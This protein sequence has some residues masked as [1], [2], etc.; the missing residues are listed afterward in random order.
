MTTVVYGQSRCVHCGHTNVALSENFKTTRQDESIAT[1]DIQ[2][3]VFT[4]I[5]S[6]F[7]STD[8]TG[9]PDSFSGSGGDFGGGGS[10]G[11]W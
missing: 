1:I 8:T 10:S 11:D 9:I 6:P 3:S 7:T 5:D 2:P 4:A